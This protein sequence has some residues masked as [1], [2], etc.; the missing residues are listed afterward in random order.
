MTE[1]FIYDDLDIID[2][3]APVVKEGQEK[4]RKSMGVMLPRKRI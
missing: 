3:S 2:N 4:G 1:R